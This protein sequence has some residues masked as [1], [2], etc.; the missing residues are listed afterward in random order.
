MAITMNIQDAKSHL[1]YLVAQAEQGA[2]VVIARAGHPAVRLTPASAQPK[3]RL[4][5]FAIDLSEA[6]VAE[7]LAPLDESDIDAWEG[8][9]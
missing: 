9:Q 6:S 4:G 8:A 2:E 5:V 7:S 1:S 3:R